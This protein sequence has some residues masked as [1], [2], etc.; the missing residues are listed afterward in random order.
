MRVSEIERKTVQ[1]GKT[2]TDFDVGKLT[3]RLIGTY[4]TQA[5]FDDLLY[6]IACQKLVRRMGE[7]GDNI[8]LSGHCG[9]I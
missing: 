7:S 3:V 8:V 1:P 4:G 9:T 2:I 5:R 6:S